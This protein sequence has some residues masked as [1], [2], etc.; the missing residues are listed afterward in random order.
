M[1][2]LD[3]PAAIE[4]AVNAARPAPRLE[5]EPGL[6]HSVIVTAAADSVVDVCRRLVADGSMVAVGLIAE[7][8]GSE[9]ELRYVLQSTQEPVLAHIVVRGPHERPEF[10]SVTTAVHGFDWHEREV[11]DTFELTFTGHPR[12][13]DF[14]LHDER[15]QEGLA[16]MR[17]HFDLEVAREGEAPG[18]WEPRRVLQ[19]PGAFVMTVGPVFSGISEPVQHLIE[20]T[21][22]DVI[23]AYPRLFYGH[24]SIEK[25]VEGV[26]VDDGLLIAE[27]F[28]QT[29]A[30]GHGLAYCHAAESALGI[31]VPP[32]A[33]LLRGLLAELERARH[34]AGLLSEICESTGLAIPAS[35]AAIHEEELL[36]LTSRL[37][38]HRYASGVLRIGGVAQAIEAAA[39]AEA[40][41]TLDEV[42][43]Q[44]RSLGSALAHSSSF[45]DRLEEVGTL[46]RDDALT[47]AL[48]GPVAR[49][50]NLALDLRSALPYEP[51]GG[52]TSALPE[53]RRSGDGEERVNVLFEEIQV[54][55]QLFGLMAR[56]LRDVGELRSPSGRH[57]AGS[58]LGWCEAPRGASFVWLR[59]GDDGRVR[60]ARFMPPSFQNFHALHRAVQGFAFQ[61]FPII[62][63]SLGLSVA[64]NDR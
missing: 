25:L 63:A 60:R 45:L 30:V 14:V 39:A 49:A 2:R 28:A 62:L 47:L 31:H 24:R 12:L 44:M 61:D 19:A 4:R 29:T 57:L 37:T 56:E 1:T 15:W 7:E 50:S 58:A 64:E 11:E 41:A 16:P 43:V 36:R 40:A 59:V 17:R 42:A 23:R 26:S 6:P 46:T 3:V 54:A 38:G 34:H 48:V 52:R 5:H 21:G 51:Y 20:T 35:E 10:P 18:D 55:A 32:R 9:W 33:A 27:R 13:G 53:R 22:E 8:L